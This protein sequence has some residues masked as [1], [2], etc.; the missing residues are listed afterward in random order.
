M[1]TNQHVISN[2]TVTMSPHQMKQTLPVPPSVV[3]FVNDARHTIQ[4]ILTGED[5]RRLIIVGPCSIHDPVAALDYATRLSEI[6]AANV[7]IVMRTYFEKPRTSVGWSGLIAD[8]DIDGTGDV[9][10]GLQIA[11]KLLLDINQLGVP[12]A[13]EM[14]SMLTPQYIDDLISFVA[15]GARTVESQPHRELASGLSMPVGFKNNS[16]GHLEPAVHAI[17][18][19]AEPKSFIGCNLNGQISAVRT[20]GNAH[21]CVI[22]RGSYTA[23]PNFQPEHITRCQELQLA[24]GQ[25]LRA[26]VDASHG[27]SGKSATRQ[28]AVIEKV[29]RDAHPFCAGIMIESFIEHGNQKSPTVY[30]KSITDECISWDETVTLFRE[31]FR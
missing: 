30:G 11:R 8:P 23:G 12:C 10:N 17:T 18:S 29:W 28:L 22:L 14:L 31:V 26:V 1:A 9:A 21:C 7:F 25:L 5:P 16:D 3:A 19:A 24:Q 15:I 20:S 4:R 2:T 27:N 6:K 13:T